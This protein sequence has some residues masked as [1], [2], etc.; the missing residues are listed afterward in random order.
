MMYVAPEQCMGTVYKSWCHED[1]FGPDDL[2]LDW[3]AVR[4]SPNYWR[5]WE[6]Q[7]KY[8]FRDQLPGFTGLLQRQ[9]AGQPDNVYMCKLNGMLE[10]WINDEAWG[11]ACQCY[12]PKV[13]KNPLMFVR[14][15]D[16]EAFSAH[17]VKSLRKGGLR[18]L[19]DIW[20]GGGDALPYIE[21]GCKPRGDAIAKVWLPDAPKVMQGVTDEFPFVFYD[22][23]EHGAVVAE[24]YGCPGHDGTLPVDVDG[25]YIRIRTYTALG[26]EMLPGG[27]ALIVAPS[28]E[29]VPGA[30]FRVVGQQEWTDIGGWVAV[31]MHTWLYNKPAEMEE[32]A[33][34]VGM[35]HGPEDDKD[36]DYDPDDE[37]AACFGPYAR[38]IKFVD[39]EFK[40][41]AGYSTPPVQTVSVKSGEIVTMR[42]AVP[43]TKL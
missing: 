26:F 40:P 30:A 1:G 20:N 5:E 42:M 14:T 18:I 28:G 22:G 17:V 21:Y 15:H 29:S 36:N 13:M 6:W 23:I 24:I 27:A 12:P 19:F 10:T 9:A 35:P 43:Y 33:Y 34:D 11:G 8:Y 37:R 38:G 31:P 25:G 32:K 16:I 39:V 4:P 7:G 41:V 2:P 3:L